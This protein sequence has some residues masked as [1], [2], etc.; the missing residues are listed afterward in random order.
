MKKSDFIAVYAEEQGITKKEA[1]QRVDS[2]LNAVGSAVRAKGSLQLAG[3]GNF[4]ITER[5][6]RTGRNPQTGEPVNIPAKAVV[7]FKPQF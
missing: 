5:K 1:Q 2:V 7:K 3:F 6:A 4:K